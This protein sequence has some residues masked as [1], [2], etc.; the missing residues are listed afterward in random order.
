MQPVRKLVIGMIAAATSGCIGAANPTVAENATIFDPLLLGTWTDSAS[1]EHAIVTQSGPRGYA[2]QYTD[3]QGHTMALTGHL[4]RN[5]DRFILDV[6]PTAEALGAYKDLVVRLHIPLVLDSI[7]PRIHVASWSPTR[8]TT[9]SGATP[10][11][12]LTAGP[13]MASYSPPAPRSF[14]SSSQHTFSGQGASRRPRHGFVALPLAERSRRTKMI[15]G[16]VR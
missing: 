14:S 1:R 4:G 10:G 12:S 16:G 13:T 2:I 11:R 15:P 8:S 6:Q 7:G 5:R 3:D 9:T